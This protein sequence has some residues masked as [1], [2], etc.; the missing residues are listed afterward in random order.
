MEVFEGFDD[1][2]ANQ[3]QTAKVPLV[4]DTDTEGRGVQLLSG[5]A[6]CNHKQDKVTKF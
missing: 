3:G 6:L 1:V 4:K 2:G 5:Q